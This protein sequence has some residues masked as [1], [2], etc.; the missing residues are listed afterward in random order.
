MDK[1]NDKNSKEDL[2]LTKQQKFDFSYNTINDEEEKNRKKNSNNNIR[3]LKLELLK[4]IKKKNK[5]KNLASCF[6]LTTILITIVAMFF[7][8]IIVSGKNVKIKKVNVRER[9]I[10]MLGDSITD[11][12]DLNKYYGDK[13][14]LINSGVSG[15]KTT[16]ILDHIERMVYQYNPKKVFLLIGTND[17]S[18]TLDI[19]EDEIFKNIKKIISGIKENTTDCKIYIESIYPV[20]D[21]DNDKIDHSMVNKRSNTKIE[22]INKKLKEYTKENKITY[23]DLYSKLKDDDN[24]L[25]LEY[26]KEG[27]HI[28]DEGYKIITKE[29]KKYMNK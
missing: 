8:F 25:K 5:Y 21:T 7:I 6:F 24:N 22:N 9:P 13:Y 2:T 14:Y 16:N 3:K 10:V 26:T 1:N 15:Y 11:F 19:S 12:Y 20:N 28:S 27:L 29:L 4:T 23:I 18:P 17:A